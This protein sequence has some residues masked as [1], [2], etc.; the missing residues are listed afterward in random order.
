MECIDCLKWLQYHVQAN[1]LFQYQDRSAADV[2]KIMSPKSVNPISHL[3][4]MLWGNEIGV[5]GIPFL[6]VSSL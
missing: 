2:K 4:Q 5:G 6:Q 1:N 3:W